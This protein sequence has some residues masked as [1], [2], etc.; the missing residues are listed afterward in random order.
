MKSKV[1]KSDV[2]KLLHV[3]ANLSKLSDAVQKDVVK[4]LYYFYCC[5][6]YIITPEFNKLTAKDFAA[7]LA[8]ANLAS[9]NDNANFIKKTDLGDELKDLNQNITSHKIKHVLVENELNELSNKVKLIP[10]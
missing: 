7:R 6:K 4:N 5:W 8:Q 3:P 2:D 10:T 9:K 1:D